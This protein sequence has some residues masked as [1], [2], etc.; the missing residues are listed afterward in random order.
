[1]E[2]SEQQQSAR[3][4]VV[5]CIQILTKS[6]EDELAGVWGIFAYVIW[7]GWML[8]ER[9][10]KNSTLPFLCPPPPVFRGCHKRSQA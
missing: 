5:V 9:L 10:Q 8:I 4:V 2:I 7:E 1:V 3:F 6:I